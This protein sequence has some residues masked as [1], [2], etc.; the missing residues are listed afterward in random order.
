VEVRTIGGDM[1]GKDKGG[2]FEE[3]VMNDGMKGEDEG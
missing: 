1:V 2:L 3:G